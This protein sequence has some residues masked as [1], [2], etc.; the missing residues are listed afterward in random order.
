MGELT[1]AALTLGPEGLLSHGA[2]HIRPVSH[3]Q[4]KAVEAVEVALIVEATST[5]FA[6]DRQTQ[7]EGEQLGRFPLGAIAA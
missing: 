4:R 1:V 7:Q 6:A 2:A 3:L 5:E